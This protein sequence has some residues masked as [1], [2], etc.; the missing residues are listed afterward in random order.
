MRRV[1]TRK[2]LYFLSFPFW[3]GS[4]IKGNVMEIDP[5]IRKWKEERQI[6]RTEE[7]PSASIVIECA[8]FLSLSLSVNVWVHALATCWR[9]ISPFILLFLL[10]DRQH[11]VATRVSPHIPFYFPMHWLTM[12]WVLFPF[13]FL[14]VSGHCPMLLEKKKPGYAWIPKLGQQ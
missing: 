8:A 13:S 2:S 11:K 7:T 9:S 3:S 4:I 5:G 6:K 12:A 14:S 1:T 10:C